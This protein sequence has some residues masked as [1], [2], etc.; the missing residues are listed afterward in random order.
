MDPYWKHMKNMGDSVSCHRSVVCHC[1]FELRPGDAGVRE[2]GGDQRPSPVTE[3]ETPPGQAASR[4]GCWL[5][6]P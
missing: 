6:L 5:R 1:S 2:C 4:V 3:A